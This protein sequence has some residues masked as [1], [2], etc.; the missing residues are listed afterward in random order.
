VLPPALFLTAS[1]YF[2]PKT[3]H[4]VRQY[5]AR[6][7]D[8]HFPE[9][10]KQHDEVIRSVSTNFRSVIDRAETL[11]TDVKQISGKVV[12]QVE[13]T[14]GLRI[15]EVLG[16]AQAIE[17]N[18]AR[19]VQRERHAQETSEPAGKEEVIAVVVEEKPIAKIVAAP[20]EEQAAANVTPEEKVP[21]LV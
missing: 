9:F 6:I 2:L 8:S 1:P 7:E 20:V 13:D 18:V 21:R 10:A 5:F 16:K 4:N 3:S 19:E 17:Q 12:R 15:G 11:G 14:T